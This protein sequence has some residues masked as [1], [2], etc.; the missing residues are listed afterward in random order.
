MKVFGAIHILIRT[1]MKQLGDQG[2][3]QDA[4]LLDFQKN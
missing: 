2:L 3:Q 4:G 1:K